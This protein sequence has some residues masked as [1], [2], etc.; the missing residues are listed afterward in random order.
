MAH[1]KTHGWFGLGMALCLLLGASPA[2]AQDDGW[3]GGWDEG[4]TTAKPELDPWIDASAAYGKRLFRTLCAGCHGRE[5]EGDGEVAAT[6]FPPP[7]DLTAGVY[8][9]RSTAS[10][11]LPTRD[12]MLRTVTNG[13]PGTEMPSWGPQLKDEGLRSLV[14]FLE[15]L[16][17]RF[18][19]EPRRDKDVLVDFESLVAPEVTPESLARGKQ[20]YADMKCAACHGELGRGDGEAAD[21][22]GRGTGTGTEVFDFTWGVYK[23]GASAESLYRAFVTGLDGTPMPSYVDSLPEE[24]DRWALAQYCMSL[25]RKRGLPFYLSERPTWYEPAAPRP[26][27]AKRTNKRPSAKTE[28]VVAP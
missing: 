7:R 13:L 27:K 5:G 15:R 23:G 20:V 2:L 6:M 1:L 4:T 24:S 3:G 11:T 9:F 16:S 14:L 26:G 25:T 28:G 18:E 17:P 19:L 10:G 21:Q 22:Y 12:D 8:R